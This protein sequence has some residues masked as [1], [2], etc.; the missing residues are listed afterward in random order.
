METPSK[1]PEKIY[2]VNPDYILR[3]ICGEYAIVPVGEECMISNAVMT[4]N[5]SAAFLMNAFQTP[6][7]EEDVVQK[8]LEEY[9]AP[10]DLLREDVHRF[11]MDTLQYKILREVMR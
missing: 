6:S 11:V 10:E 1:E 5:D 2:Q 3:E 7:T 4:P 8:A 9:D